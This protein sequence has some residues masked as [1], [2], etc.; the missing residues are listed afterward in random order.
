MDF[1]DFESKLITKLNTTFS[2]TVEVRSY[3]D[4]FSNYISQ[5]KHIGGAVLIAWQG[6]F[7][8]EPEGNNQSVLVQE[9]VYNWQ[10]TVLK[11]NLSRKK[12]QT[13][14]YDAIETIR[15]AL[16]GFTPDGFDDC[17]VLYPVSAGFLERVGGFYA[18]QITMGHKIEE[19]EA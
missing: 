13:S 15:T 12:N 9:G 2:N 16:S 1:D 18:Y 14:S 6:A 17:S 3:P 10:F 5:L 7:W 8:E 19:S 11:K 4:D